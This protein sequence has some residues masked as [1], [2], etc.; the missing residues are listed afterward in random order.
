MNKTSIDWTG[1]SWNPVTGCT[2][3]SPGCKNCYAE[4]LGERLRKMG[5]PRWGKGFSEV[6]VHQDKV[7]EPK[8]TPGSKM[9]FVNSMSDLLHPDVPLPFI[10]RCFE[11]MASTQHRYQVLTKRS[12]RWPAVSAAVVKRIGS[13]PQNVWP[14]VSIEDRRHL[15]RLGGLARTGDDQTVRMV[16][17]EPLLESLGAP[18]YLAGLLR[19]SGIG[20]V[21]SGGESGWRA[22]PAEERWFE[23]ILDACQA[24]G[25]PLWH[26][27]HGGRGVTHR[28]KR[29]GALAPIRGSLWNQTPSVGLTGQPAQ[30]DLF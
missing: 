7:D 18:S 4:P 23:D 17:F 14:G 26:K 28:A 29:A 30:A 9:I 3:C 6:V 22:R 2:K 25:I 21:V 12:N 15:S 5:N 13:W 19:S 20:W 16:S 27:Q 10:V 8:K 24:G 11:T 1:L